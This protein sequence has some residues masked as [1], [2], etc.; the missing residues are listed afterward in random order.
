MAEVNLLEK[1]KSWMG[2]GGNNYQDERLKGY[3]DEVKQY[4]LDGGASKEIVDAPTS[5]GVIARG[6]S[7]LYYEGV[8]SPYFKERATQICLKKVNKDVQT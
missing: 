3:I 4:L 8:L 5:A 7:D 2:F 1:V 6:V